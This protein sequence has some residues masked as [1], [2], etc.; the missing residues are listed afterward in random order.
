MACIELKNICAL[1]KKSDTPSSRNI[2]DA[3]P[4]TIQQV[5]YSW[6]KQETCKG[7]HLLLASTCS[8]KQPCLAY[9]DTKWRENDKCQDYASH[10]ILTRQFSC[11][12]ESLH[13]SSKSDCVLNVRQKNSS[14]YTLPMFTVGQRDNQFSWGIFVNIIRKP[15]WD[16]CS[17]KS[18]QVFCQFCANLG[19]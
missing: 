17:S 10:G 19:S 14:K 3:V 15:I 1:Q 2:K 9:L 18:P 11:A 5:K 12:M 6:L 8:L 4:S 16:L 13:L 7:F